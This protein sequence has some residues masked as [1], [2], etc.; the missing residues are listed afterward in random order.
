MTAVDRI[1]ST[2]AI[3]RVRMLAVLV[4]VAAAG[5]ALAQNVVVFVNGDPIT[6]IDIEQRTKFIVLTNQKQPPRQEVLDQLIDEVLKIREGRRWG[7]EASTADVDNNYSGMARRMGQ[8]AD[9][10]TQNLAQKGV[11]AGTLKS[12]RPRPVTIAAFGQG[13]RL[14][15]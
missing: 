13:G 15:V 6:A 7:I 8:S 11:N 9:Q 2:S 5:S 10:L 3:M 4:V 1:K 14:G 12:R